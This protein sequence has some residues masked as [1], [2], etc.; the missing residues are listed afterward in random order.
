MPSPIVV[1]VALRH[2][3]SAPLAVAP[4]L[5]RLTGAPLALVTSYAYGAPSFVVASDSHRC[6]SGPSMRSG[7]RSPVRPPELRAEQCGEAV[8][9]LATG[10]A[11]LEVRPHAGDRDVG[12]AA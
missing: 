1:G 5:A 12:P 7:G 8:A 9:V 6:V 11:A 4:V 3:D 2:D 10:R